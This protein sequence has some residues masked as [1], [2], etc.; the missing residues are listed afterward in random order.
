MN[1]LVVLFLAVSLNSII[2]SPW[3]PCSDFTCPSGYIGRI[4]KET[5]MYVFYFLNKN[6]F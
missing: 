4:G 5:S 1:K 6:I 3:N 2:V